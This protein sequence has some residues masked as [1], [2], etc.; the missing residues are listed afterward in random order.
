MINNMTVETMH[1]KNMLQNYIQKKY[2]EK[3]KIN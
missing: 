2:D 1:P 3:E